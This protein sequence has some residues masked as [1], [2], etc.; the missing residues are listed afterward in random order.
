MCLTGET[1][2][3]A[4]ELTTWTSDLKRNMG[5]AQPFSVIC[6]RPLGAGGSWADIQPFEL[7]R[8]ENVIEIG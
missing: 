7:E 3:A 8:Y 6:D 4:G 5:A 2:G 1:H